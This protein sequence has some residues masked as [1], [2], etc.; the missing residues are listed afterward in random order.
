VSAATIERTEMPDLP[1]YVDLTLP[2]G[3]TLRDALRVQALGHLYN[4][5]PATVERVVAEAIEIIT[6]EKADAPT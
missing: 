1:F 6:K 3:S 2:T 4:Q 5:H